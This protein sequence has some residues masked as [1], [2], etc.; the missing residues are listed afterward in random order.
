ME[1]LRLGFV[2]NHFNVVPVRINDKSCIVCWL[3]GAS[4]VLGATHMHSVP[5]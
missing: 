1:G 4:Y 2:A 5:K 3:T